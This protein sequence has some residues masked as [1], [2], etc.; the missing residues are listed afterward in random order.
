[1]PELPEV[2]TVCRGMA[3]ALTGARIVRVEQRRKDLR[4]PFPP[5][6]AERLTGR[7]IKVIERRAKYILIRLDNGETLLLHLGMSGRI[8]LELTPT[9]LRKHDHLVVHFAGKAPRLTFNDPRRFGLCDLIAKD[10]ETKHPMLQH[11]GI[12]P[13]SGALTPA[14]LGALFRGRKTA[15]KAALLDQRLIAGLGN[16]YVCEALFHACISPKRKAG[17]LKMDELKKLAPAIRDVLRAAINAGGSSLRDYVQTDGELGYFQNHF[18]VYAREG[19]PCPGCKCNCVKTGGI[20]RITQGGRSSFF[21]A[22]K[23]K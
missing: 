5:H 2:E 13:L 19:K 7:K 3:K 11:L 14:K 10:S 12:E 23:Q 9:A 20:K 4:Q 15:V 21:C 18:A 22:T 1:M 17:S 6:L 16:I 8:L